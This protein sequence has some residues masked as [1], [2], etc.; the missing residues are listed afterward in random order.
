MALSR[1]EMSKI[2]KEKGFQVV[3]SVTKELNILVV[4]DNV[5]LTSSKCIKAQKH[6]VKIIRESEFLNKKGF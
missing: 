6:N 4:A 5:D 1:S 3:D 2:A